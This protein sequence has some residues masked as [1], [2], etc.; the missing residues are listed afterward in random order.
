[1]NLIVE[2]S[3]DP[4]GTYAVESTGGFVTWTVSS[5]LPGS[6]VTLAVRLRGA[7]AGTTSFRFALDLTDGSGSPP[8]AVMSN[9]VTIDFVATAVSALDLLPW[10]LLAVLSVAIVGVAYVA[11]WRRRSKGSIED[12]FVV[13]YGGTL[14]AHRSKSLMP[15]GDED[16]VVSMFTAVQDFVRHTF[17]QE[18]TSRC[19]P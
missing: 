2:A 18:L 12:V 3:L 17:S 4:N 1:M 14:I 8:K 6:V 13:D 19:G 7:E 9:D 16:L 10:W 15:Y 5:I 11:V